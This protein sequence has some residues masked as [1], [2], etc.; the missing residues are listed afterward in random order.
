[1]QHA[2]RFDNLRYA[3]DLARDRQ[4]AR[5]MRFPLITLIPFA[6]VMVLSI[7]LLP[8]LNPR[9]GSAAV[10]LTYET[11]EQ[12]R[13][14]IWFSVAPDETH[15]V[16]QTDDRK[17]FR[18]PLDTEDMQAVLP[19]VNYLR[20]RTIEIQNAGV[21]SLDVDPLALQTVIAIDQTLSY[22]HIRPVL[23]ALASAGIAQYGFE[24]KNV[25]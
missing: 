6:L 2:N 13:P 22:F 16:I 11:S 5:F 23:N 4:R 9:L 1:M 17:I 3:F 8:K 21:L 18:W 25:N 7:H 15:I 19:F 20:A 14:T 24:T 10:P 12:A